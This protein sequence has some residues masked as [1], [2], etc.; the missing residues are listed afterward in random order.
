MMCYLDMTFCPFWSECKHG[1]DCY[2]ALTEEV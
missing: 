1:D 2:R